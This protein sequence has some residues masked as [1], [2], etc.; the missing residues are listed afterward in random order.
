MAKAM[1]LYD[2]HEPDMLV[3]D[4]KETLDT[5][6]V[7]LT[8]GQGTLARGTVI[9]FPAATPGVGG[10][11]WTGADGQAADCVLCDDADTG[12][13]GATGSVV[14]HAYRTGHLCRQ[15]LLFGTGVTELTE[16]AEK[17]LRDGGIM[18]SDAVL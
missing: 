8:A 10:V 5:K 3:Y 16:A 15:A 17:Q 6:T 11:A 7:Q 4:T 9:A 1:E 13:S 14:G 12:A 18:L 2:K